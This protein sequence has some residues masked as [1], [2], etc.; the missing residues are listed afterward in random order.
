MREQKAFRRGLTRRD[1]LKTSLGASTVALASG[2]LGWNYAWAQGSDRIRVGVIGCGGR[3]TGAARDAVNAAPNVEI[4]ALGD[5]FQ[6]RAEGAFNN[7]QNLGDRFKVT[8][9]RVF[10][11]FDNY[12]KVINSG[13]DMVILATPPGFRPIHFRAAV[14]AGKHVFMEKPV[15]VCPTGVRMVLEAA[16]LAKQKGLGVVAG[17]QRRHQKGYIETIKRIHDGAIGKIVAAQC[18]WNQGG[19]WKWDRQPGMNDIEWQIRNWLYFTWLSGDHIVE[20]HIHNL[21]VI[22]WVLQAY[23]VKC[24]GVGGRQVRTDPVY[25]HIYDHFAIEYEYPGGVRVLS[26][27]RQIDGCANRVGEYVIGTE[28][29]SDPGGWIRGKIQWRNEGGSNPYVQE[30]TDLINSIREG[31]PLNEGEQV[32]LSTLTA[33]MGRMAAYTGQEVTWDFVLKESKLNLVK[34]IKEFG[35]MPVDPVAIPGRTPLV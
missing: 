24:V 28:G 11:G 34:D 18:Y 10:W 25:G 27:C 26:M 12:L 2:V 31:K 22:N 21:D 16:N 29:V 32:A 19:L 33:I 6:D 7:L 14:E 23:P 13:V 9:E 3:G 20:Q 4:W 30:H 35:E 8:R 17:T 5:L 15:A 1:F